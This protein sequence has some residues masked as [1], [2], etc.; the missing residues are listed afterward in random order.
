MFWSYKLKFLL[1]I[2]LLFVFSCNNY[3]S[4]IGLM[5]PA[6]LVKEINYGSEIYRKG[7]KEGCESGYAGYASSFTKL[8]H[9]WVQDPELTKNKEYYQIWKDAYGYC[10]YYA[11]MTDEHGLGNWR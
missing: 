1:L 7:Y 8:F 9:D 5:S 2:I 3:H 11:M 10:A 4:D 6:S